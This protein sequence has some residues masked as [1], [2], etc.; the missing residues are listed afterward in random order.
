MRECRLL[1][2]EILI[3]QL[4]SFLDICSTGHSLALFPPPPPSPVTSLL[5]C[6]PSASKSRHSR[7]LN[8]AYSKPCAVESEARQILGMYALYVPSI[9]CPERAWWGLVKSCHRCQFE[10]LLLSSYNWPKCTVA[11]LGNNLKVACGW[12]KPKLC[13]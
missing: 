10:V 13:L 5:C 4:F 11:A 7:G 3:S 2:Q 1:S 12:E 6:F 9:C 8:S